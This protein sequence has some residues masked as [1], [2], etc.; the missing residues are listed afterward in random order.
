MASWGNIFRGIRVVLLLLSISILFFLSRRERNHQ[1]SLRCGVGPVSL[2]RWGWRGMAALARGGATGPI[3]PTGPTPHLIITFWL[4]CG[5]TLKRHGFCRPLCPHPM[6]GS[7]GQGLATALPPVDGTEWSGDLGRVP[8]RDADA[9]PSGGAEIEFS[10][11]PAKIESCLL[12]ACD[13]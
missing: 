3:R 9:T 12:A 5:G 11:F 6:Q 2:P 13:S 4:P 7:P 8:R 10:S 1:A